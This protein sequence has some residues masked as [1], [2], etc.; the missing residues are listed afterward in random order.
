MKRRVAWAYAWWAG[1]IVLVYS[2]IML[3]MCTFQ[4]V[5]NPSLIEVWKYAL[6]SSVGYTVGLPLGAAFSETHSK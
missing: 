2:L 1:F 5:T 3:S 4:E 6:A